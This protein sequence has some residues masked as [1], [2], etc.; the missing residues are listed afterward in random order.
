[1]AEKSYEQARE[2]YVQAQN[3]KPLEQYP[4]VKLEEIAGIL[5]EIKNKSE[6]YEKMVDGA[7]KLFFA[8]NYEQAKEQYQKALE[9]YP[10]EKY[11]AQQISMINE[12][13][14]L[15]D[16][17]I[18]A[19]NKADAL[20]MA[21]DYQTAL[22]EY[23]NA[24]K[25]QP[26][27][28][29]PAEKIREIEGILQQQ[30]VAAAAAKE[31]EGQYLGALTKADAL[32]REKKWEDALLAY[33]D[34]AAI[35]PE[36]S[37]PKQQLEIIDA[38][39]REIARQVELD[40]NYNALIARAGEQMLSQNYPAA[41][42][43]YAEA[44]ALKP[45]EILPQQKITEIDG[46]MQQLAAAA[47]AKAAEER[48][49]AEA[50]AAAKEKEAR[51]AGA[52]A[53]G[54]DLFQGQKYAEAQASYREASVLKPEEAYPKLQLE[55]I[56]N[57]LR[58]I[59]RQEE[60]DKNYNALIDK[61]SGQMGS[62]NYPAARSTYEEALAL[63]PSETLPQQKMIEIDG[64]MQRLAEAEKAAAEAAA[65][66]KQKE[67][68]YA[69]TIASGDRLFQGKQYTEAQAA[70]REASGIKP[71]E[72]Y[73]KQQLDAINDRFREIARQEE[74]DKNYDALITRAGG[75]MES[76]NY[77]AARSTYEEALTL[78]PAEALPQQKIAEIEG[79][80]QQMAAA[81]KAAAEAAAVAKEREERYAAA[82]ADGDGLFQ[83][84][85]YAGAQVAYREASS[86]KPEET[87]P[88]KQLEIID[89]RLKEIAAKEELDRNYQAAITRG[90]ELESGGDLTGA[91]A[92][93]TEAQALKPG[94]ALPKDRIAGIRKQMDQLAAEEAFEK[95]FNGF[96][97]TADKAF[98][99]GLYKDARAA[100]QSA[101]DLKPDHARANERLKEADDILATLAR[102]EEL[103]RKYQEA[104]AY[105]DKHMSVQ[106]YVNA[107][108]EF[109]VANSL[110]P[111]ESYPLE[112]LSEIEGILAEQ[113]R[114][115]ELNQK[116][117]Y[118][119]SQA[120][121]L[122]RKENFEDAIS[123]YEEALTY[124]HG[125]LYAEKQIVE[126]KR[127][128]ASRAEE[129]EKSYN[130]AITKG[131]NAFNEQSYEMARLQFERAL[132]LKPAEVYP[133]ERLKEVNDIIARERQVMQE[134]YDKAIA[135][136]DKFY[137]AKIYDSAIE[138]YR[139]AADLKKEEEYPTVMIHKIL[140]IFSER[141]IVTVNKDPLLVTNS[142]TRKFD[143]MPV[144]VKDRKSNYLYF[145][146]RNA[147]PANH[148]LIISYGRDQ[149]KNG[150]VVVKIPAGTEYNEFLVRISAQ[151]KWFSDDNNWITF[152]PEGGDLEVSLL[153]I[154]YSD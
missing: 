80:L 94:E 28:A 63:K 54:D 27:E 111:A 72:A 18:K 79:I 114:Q 144:P 103:T 123:A 124:K 140:K 70:Y 147:S 138:S 100:Y 76:Q 105:G 55:A 96:M 136:A 73:P 22:L 86:F 126:I 90:G 152:Y 91:L 64:I 8:D 69:T 11:P 83:Q 31:Q 17:Y 45:A 151:Y 34:A 71:E 93:F 25:V 113:Q 112:K 110:K 65:A 50:A 142:T 35:K 66:E 58:E 148:K 30:A 125:D 141:A 132:E 6:T 77:P 84:K 29:Y 127:L 47:E 107:K 12:I 9:I 145:K 117:A 38:R 15:R 56:D 41:R 75:Q 109:Q 154:S 149:T 118:L 36:E 67:E 122:Y 87:Y 59:A 37:Y 1:M 106:D 153:Q 128:V 19:I 46:I 51:Y 39:L 150:G 97:E 32:F 88:K 78:K 26:E 130:V 119:L 33:R 42:S 40:K 14:G 49:T 95:Q 120:D 43:T 121:E 146:A 133:Q 68:R 81:E 137:A 74:L 108:Y 62:Q 24:A 2:I 104:V 139:T 7:D 48:K 5:D 23:R 99:S 129:V 101:L 116:Y 52:V 135:D 20:L 92:A 82:I 57:L 10:T 85:Q 134:A 60:L 13:L 3:L 21:Q 143:F 44:L 89:T 4:K 61:A 53:N 115:K 98:S 16:T 102:E 131:D